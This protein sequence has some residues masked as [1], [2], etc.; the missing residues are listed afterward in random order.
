MPNEQFVNVATRK[1]PKAKIV[2][3]KLI[4]PFIVHHNETKGTETENSLGT[5]GREFISQPSHS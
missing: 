1:N 4:L 5:G 3:F 2:G